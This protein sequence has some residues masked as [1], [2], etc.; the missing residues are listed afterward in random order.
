MTRILWR[1]LH[2]HAAWLQTRIPGLVVSVI[3]V[4]LSQ[5]FLT[6]GAGA[7]ENPSTLHEWNASRLV[8]FYCAMFSPRPATQWLL[9]LHAVNVLRRVPTRYLPAE[10]LKQ[11]MEEFVV[12]YSDYFGHPMIVPTLVLISDKSRRR[13]HL[14]D[15][16]ASSDKGDGR[17]S[18]IRSYKVAIGKHPGTH[19]LTTGLDPEDMITPE[20]IFWVDDLVDKP[21]KRYMNGPDLGPRVV[22]M[23]APGKRSPYDDIAL[24]GSKPKVQWTIGKARTYGCLRMYNKEVTELYDLLEATPSKGIGVLVIIT[25]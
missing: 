16:G 24:H 18:P 25:P 3:A 1:A 8:S 23:R 5:G 11:Y 4:V 21:L 13:V 15:L 9:Q 10:F 20:G 12:G 14:F 19:N 7:E 2:F 6:A 22:S 17:L